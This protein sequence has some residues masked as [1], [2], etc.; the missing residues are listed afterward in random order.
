LT[1][2][3]SDTL[4]AGVPSRQ[5]RLRVRLRGT[6]DQLALAARVGTALVLPNGRTRSNPLGSETIWDV[7]QPDGRIVRLI[8]ATRNG[9]AGGSEF[10]LT[11]LLLA[12]R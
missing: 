11:A 12:P 10:R 2:L 7:A 8:A 5:C 3:A 6:A 9:P 4:A 1:Y